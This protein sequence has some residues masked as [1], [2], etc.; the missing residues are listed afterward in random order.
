LERRA[1]AS[2]TKATKDTRRTKTKEKDCIINHPSM[3]S[4]NSLLLALLSLFC[5]D[6]LEIILAC[7]IDD[8]LDFVTLAS[9]TDRGISFKETVSFSS[10]LSKEKRTGMS[11]VAI[12]CWNYALK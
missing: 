11:Y 7:D 4:L 2:E 12:D 6:R 9:V 5:F 1:L 8:E 10:F 3:G